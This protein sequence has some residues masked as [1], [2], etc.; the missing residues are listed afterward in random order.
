MS[1]ELAEDFVVCQEPLGMHAVRVG[2]EDEFELPGTH[3][4]GNSPHSL[5]GIEDRVPR[6][7]EIIRR[8]S[9]SETRGSPSDEGV[10]I[11]AAGLKILRLFAEAS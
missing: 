3:K 9:E 10:T 7:V 1:L 5:N 8:S 6:P 4:R 11:E 2:E